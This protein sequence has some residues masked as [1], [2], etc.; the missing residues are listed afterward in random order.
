MPEIGLAGAYEANAEDF[1]GTDGT[2]WS[3]MVAARFTAFDGKGRSARL[4]HARHEE[5]RASSMR[6]MLSQ[7]VGLEVRKAYYNLQA[8]SKR[9]EQATRAVEMSK[10]SLR[11]VTDRYKEGLT[12]VVEL[13]DAETA[14]TRARTREVGARRDMLLG[15]ASLD[16][17][18]GRL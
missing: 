16:L 2:N 1:F 17:A 11:I 12:T 5:R 13:L 10:E 7:S 3:V 4:R 14:L 6:E 18:V 15:R 9:L 8:A